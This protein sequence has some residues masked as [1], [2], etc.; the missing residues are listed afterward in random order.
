MKKYFYYLSMTLAGMLLLNSCDNDDDDIRLSNVPQAVVKTFDIMYP[1]ANG[2]EWEKNRGYYVADFWRAGTAI[3]AWFETKGEWRM[4]E[5]DLGR[6][7]AA[8]PE[9][10]QKAFIDGQYATWQV[11][12]LDKY[13]RPD[14]TFYLIEVET[15]GERDRDLYYA[16]DGR[17]LKDEADREGHEVTPDFS[18]Q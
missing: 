12:D 8:L 6:N 17:L 18:Y 7:L 10:V 15:K 11:D 2:V 3:E 1:D 16:S 9:A 5:I 14:D 13:E 4:T